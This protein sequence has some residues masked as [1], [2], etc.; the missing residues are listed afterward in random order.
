MLMKISVVLNT[1]NEAEKLPQALL[2]AKGW[3]DEIV[4]V[5]MGSAD[6]TL[7]IAEKF[8]A[9]VF[10]HK[11]LPYVEPARNFALSMSKGDWILVLDPDERISE[12]LAEKLQQIVKEGKYDVVNIARKNIIF[13]RWIKHTNWWPDK[14]VR[15]FKKGKVSWSGRIHQ[16]PEVKGRMLTLPAVE[17]LAIEHLNYDT[18]N[19]FLER[20]NRYSEIAVKN[21]LDSGE[22]FS[23]LS[24]SWNPTRLFIQRYFRHAGFLDGFYGLAL[25]LL[26]FYAQLTE[27]VKLW[28]KEKSE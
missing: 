22:K 28:E 6:E 19:Q 23:W 15:F 11:H 13:G 9:K 4:I 17:D 18:V 12:G 20:Q 2:S 26:A 21:R 25:S 27:E 24:F 7:K 1:Y 14:H 8:E 5:D 3:V 16:Y 10:K